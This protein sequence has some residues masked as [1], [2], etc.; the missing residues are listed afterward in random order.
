MIRALIVDDERLARGALTRLIEKDDQFQIVAQASSGEEAL[1][2]MQVSQVDVVFLDVEMPGLNGLEV[3]ARLA[4]WEHPPLV[5]FST[6]YDQYAIKAFET[7]AIDYILKPVRPDRFEKTFARIKEAI[8]T[9]QPSRQKLVALQ[10]DLIAEGKLKRL[11]GYQPRSKVRRV[12]D[13]SGVFYFEMKYGDI[14]AHLADQDLVVRYTLQE[15]LALLDSS[16]FTQTHKSYIVNLDKVANVEPVFH[17]NF[18]ITLKG[19]KA[20]KVP[21]T[22][23]YLETFKARLGDW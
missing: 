15:V 14:H 16:Q 9:K 18:Q 12:F 19:E 5:V 13:L 22:R 7:N 21:L 3:A 6:A 23:T 10:D 20:F 11:V 2:K 8:R 1:Q 4:E 17:G